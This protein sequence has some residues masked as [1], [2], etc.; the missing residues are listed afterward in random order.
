MQASKQTLYRIKELTARLSSVSTNLWSNLLISYPQL[1]RLPWGGGSGPSAVYAEILD[2]M[3]QQVHKHLAEND[4]SVDMQARDY[5]DAFLLERS[6]LE[7]AGTAEHGFTL[8]QLKTM[9][10]NLWLAGQVSDLIL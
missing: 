6:R 2:F 8:D 1:L 5:I 3:E 7:A 4:Y 9:C 10:F